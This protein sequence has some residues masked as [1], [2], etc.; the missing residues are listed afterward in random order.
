MPLYDK[1]AGFLKTRTDKE[2]REFYIKIPVN[3]LVFPSPRS[4]DVAFVPA[5]FSGRTEHFVI[6]TFSQTL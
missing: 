2:G 5:A 4:V 6:A 3:S 1:P